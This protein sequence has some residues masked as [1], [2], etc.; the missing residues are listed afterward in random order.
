MLKLYQKCTRHGEKL[1]RNALERREKAGKE[2]AERLGERMGQY[3]TPRPKGALI[4][5]HAASVGES[6][7]ALILI[8]RLLQAYPGLNI[9]VTTGTLTSAKM[10]EKNLPKQAFH[11]FYP[12]D[13]PKWVKSFLD[14]WSRSNRFVVRAFFG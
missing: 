14:Y 8:N 13:H 3:T 1:L 11:Q 10:M 9:L 2:D 5:L 6:Q 12:L 7:S 4:W